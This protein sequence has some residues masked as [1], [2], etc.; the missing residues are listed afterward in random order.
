MSTTTAP[1]IAETCDRR[2]IEH[3]VHCHADHFEPEEVAKSIGRDADVALWME[4]CAPAIPTLFVKPPL[5]FRRDAT[6]EIGMRLHPN[7]RADIEAGYLRTLV[8]L[9]AGV[10]VHVHH[11]AWTCNEVPDSKLSA[12][13]RELHDLA[14]AQ[15]SQRLDHARMAEMVRSSLEWLRSVTGLALDEWH[16]VHGCWAFGASDA[17]ICTL[18][19]ELP[20]LYSLGCRAD[21]SFPAGRRRCDP[22]WDRP[23]WVVPASGKRAFEAGDP[24]DEWSADRMLV[25]ASKADDWWC[26]LDTYS[27]DSKRLTESTD[28]IERYLALCP[29]VNGTAYVKTC[30]HGMNAH[31][32]PRADD[33][34]PT[35]GAFARELEQ[36]CS[37]AGVPVKFTTTE[38]VV[39]ELSR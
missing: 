6:T 2:G 16:F 25:W 13:Q 19:D 20:L 11:E 29:V 9:G 39:A 21:F 35:L 18:E 36:K 32:W 24:R 17:E 33:P 7:S 34:Q 15:D 8:A 38:R 4:R 5:G 27:A 28:K 3:V 23:K 37:L 31:Y 1:D 30:G 12:G 14:R 10:G 22:S 26:G